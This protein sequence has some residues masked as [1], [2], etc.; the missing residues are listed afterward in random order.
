MAHHSPPYLRGLMFDL[1]GSCDRAWQIGT[2]I[3]L[4]TGIAQIAFGGPP[5]KKDDSKSRTVVWRRPGPRH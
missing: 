5:R 4:T 2:M 3:G 1:F